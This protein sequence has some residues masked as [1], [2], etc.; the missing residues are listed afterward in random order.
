[1][2]GVPKR[3][4]PR[5][6]LSEAEILDAALALLDAGGP[7][8]ASIRRIAAAVGCAPNAV[9]TYFPDRAA[10][11]RA[12]VDR[13]LDEVD[14]ATAGARGGWRE[15]LEALALEIRSRLVAHPGAVPLV[16]ATPMDGPHALVLGERLLGLLAEAGLPG[17]EAARGAYVLIVYVLGAVALEVADV[18]HIGALPPEPERI[19]ARQA[20]FAGIAPGS[21]P[22]SAAAAAVMGAWVGTDQ[23]RWGLRRALAGLTGPA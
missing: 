7:D 17:Q 15:R 14:T 3:P 12:L 4:G 9:Y 6:V 23:F 21:F 22:R 11:G 2:T 13:L 20:A 5:Q 19:A 16:L 18:P 8:A 10:V 1:M